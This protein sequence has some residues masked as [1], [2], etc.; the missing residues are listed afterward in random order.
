MNG[1]RSEVQ[2]ETM[3]KRIH[4][5]PSRD[6]LPEAVVPLTSAGQVLIGNRSAKAASGVLRE[7]APD[8][9][10]LDAARSGGTHGE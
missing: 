10:P 2:I 4:F 3:G 7:E 9:P 6:S 5:S 8:H 1:T